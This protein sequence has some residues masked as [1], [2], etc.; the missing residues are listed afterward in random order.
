M[1]FPE[2]QQMIIFS[3]AAVLF[4]GF[5]IFRYYP[6]AKQKQRIEKRSNDQMLAVAKANTHGMQLPFLRK[7]IAAVRAKTKKYETKVPD[8]RQFAELWRQ[9][10]SVM[11]KHNLKEQLVQP[12]EEIQGSIANCIPIT[13]ECSGTLSQI[14]ELFKSLQDFERLIRIENIQLINDKNYSGPLKMKAQ[15]SVYYRPVEG[16]TI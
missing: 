6:L 4:L 2:K 12:G 3:I 16:K 7:H 8:N 13:I 5:G 11:N 9:F 1:R 14:F 10:A 15:A